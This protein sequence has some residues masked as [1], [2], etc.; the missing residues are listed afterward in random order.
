MEIYTYKVQTGDSIDKIAKKIYGCSS[1]KHTITGYI[2]NIGIN[3]KNIKPGDEIIVP[4]FP[5]TEDA[6]KDLTLEGHTA[7]IQL[8]ELENNQ[9]NDCLKWES[10]ALPRAIIQELKRL[11]YFTLPAG[12]KHHGAVAGGLYQHSLAVAEQLSYLTHALNLEWQRKE[13]PIIIGLLHDLCKLNQYILNVEPSE[14][15]GYKIEWNKN[16]PYPGHGE[17]SIWLISEI[18]KNHPSFRLTP[19]ELACIRYHMEAFAPKEEWEG[20]NAAIKRYPN[21]IYTHTAD[22]IASKILE[23]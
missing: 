1:A 12:M 7:I 5:V 3:W 13:S 8:L 15:K 4:S 20:M 21:I 19:E 10:E 23:K 9:F 18:E 6:K 22:M 14:P 16:N 17:A 11:D 2:G